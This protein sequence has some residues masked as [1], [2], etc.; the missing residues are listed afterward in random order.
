MARKPA[1]TTNTISAKTTNSTSSASKKK[2]RQDNKKSN[3][4]SK[5]TVGKTN[6]ITKAG[7][8][9]VIK[10]P[11][12]YVIITHKDYLNAFNLIPV[13]KAYL[14]P[15]KPNKEM[16]IQ[17]GLYTINGSPAKAQDIQQYIL[18]SIP[19][20]IS[21]TL[22]RIFY[23]ICLNFYNDSKKYGR[24]CPTELK[25]YVRDLLRYAG[26]SSPNNREIKALLDKINMYN[27]YTIV[28]VLK[29]QVMPAIQ[30]S[31]DKDHK[32]ITIC[33]P[34]MFS[35]AQELY[36]K[37]VPYHK[38]GYTKPV[39]SYIIKP[40]ILNIRNRYSAEI[41]HIVSTVIERVGSRSK[42][43]PHIRANEIVE[44]CPQLKQALDQASSAD[45]NQILKRAFMTAWGKIR[46]VTYLEAYTK[47]NLPDPDN[48]NDIPTIK[49]MKIIYEFKHDGKKSYLVNA[50]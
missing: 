27:T 10:M 21:L 49:D 39:Y 8:G 31:Y 12:N 36:D 4:G 37:S 20:G 50:E 30:T 42:K 40:S 41:I 32:V 29:D 35:L 19:M 47:I 5:S 33:S 15:I 1:Q 45:K 38:D 7:A 46:E 17:E 26:K 18:D 44:R 22:L 11:D 14:Q 9:D 28:G 48:V 6:Y 34:Y 24:K 25:I 16:K 2:T 23:S 3:E 13:G 43:I